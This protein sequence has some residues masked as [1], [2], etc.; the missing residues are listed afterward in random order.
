MIILKAVTVDQ[1]AFY[2]QSHS[3]IKLCISDRQVTEESNKNHGVKYIK[4]GFKGVLLFLS[5]SSSPDI[6]WD[7]CHYSQAEQRDHY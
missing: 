1:L 3:V 7:G 2:W 4:I 6:G 5:G